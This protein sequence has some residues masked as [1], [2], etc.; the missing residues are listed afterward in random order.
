MSDLRQLA[1]KLR[2]AGRPPVVFISKEAKAFAEAPKGDTPVQRHFYV[3]RD[4]I[5][6][7][8]EIFVRLTPE[9]Q[10]MLGLVFKGKA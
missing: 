3:S 1:V 4:R 8:D 10:A 9:L 6:Q 7:S 2:E 5:E